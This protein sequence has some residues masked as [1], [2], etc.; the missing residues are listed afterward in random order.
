MQCISALFASMSFLATS[1]SNTIY[2]Y[3][4]SQSAIHSFWELSYES[5]DIQVW[6]L[7]EPLE[8]PSLRDPKFE[9]A[10]TAIKSNMR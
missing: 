7:Q 3:T 4:V 10:T 1:A 8:I 2:S 5:L 9:N 6:L